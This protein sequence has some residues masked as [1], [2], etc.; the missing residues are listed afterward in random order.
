MNIIAFFSDD[1]APKAGL[2]PTLRIRLV[3]DGTLTITDDAMSEVGDGWYKYDFTAY[4]GSVDYAIRCD[5]GV[6]LTNVDRYMFAGNENYVDD[7]WG[8]ALTDHTVSGSI[9]AAMNFTYDM[10]G[11][12]WHLVGDQMVF[13]KSDNVTEVARFNLFDATGVP[14]TQSAYER[15][16]V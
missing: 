4:T 15:T 11:G 9:G 13:Y 2:V 16:R 10:E 14:T 1:G 7:I 6:T 12:R 8:A 5:G 3:S